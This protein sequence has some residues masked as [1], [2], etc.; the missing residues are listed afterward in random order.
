[1]RKF[2]LPAIFSLVIVCANATIRTVS[3]TPSTLAQ[4]NTIQA[5]V[6]ASS[7]GDTVYVHGSPNQYASFAITNKQ[8][9]I[10]GPGWSPDKNLPFDAEIIGCTITGTSCSNTE[11]QGLV[12]VGTIAISTNHPDNL[13]FIRNRFY[14]L[15]LQ[16]TEG[17]VS[18]TGYL[19]EGNWFDNSQVSAATNSTYQN[20]LFQNNYFHEFGCCVNGN[21]SG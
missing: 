12:F 15:S 9:V 6:D 21:I 8:L 2:Y 17:G 10:I 3:N 11:I 14:R 13:R 19:F 4:F 16:I 20:F 7:S 18:Y 1:M 5:A